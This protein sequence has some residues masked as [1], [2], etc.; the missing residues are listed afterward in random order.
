MS[1]LRVSC[2]MVTRDR[3]DLAE[4]AVACFAAQTWTNRELVILDDGDE[5]YAPMLAPFISAGEAIRYHRIQHDS[6]TH[7]GG[8]RNAT[9]ELAEGDW[10]AQWDDDEWYGPTRIER[11]MAALNPGDVASALRWTLMTVDSPTLGPLTFRA[12]AGFATPGTVLHRRDAARYPDLARGED[13]VFLK[14]LRDAGGVAVLGKDDANLFVRCFHG[15]NTWNEGHFLRRLH[16]RPVDWPSYANARW[17]HRDLRRHRAF[18]LTAAERAT[19]E[20][21]DTWSAAHTHAPEA[22]NA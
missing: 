1:T 21:L 16:R 3:R 17:V 6:S 19:S 18:N 7:L 12:D 15:S 5:D 9:I 22:A 14:S 10:C 13:A 2:L 8:L 4:R 11:Q 20:A